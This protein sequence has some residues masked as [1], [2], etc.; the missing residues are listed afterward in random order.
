MI[1]QALAMEVIEHA[2]V[3]GMKWGVR[4]ASQV[5]TSVGKAFGLNKPQH[6]DAKTATVLK[7][8]KLSELSNEDLK[9]L[10]KRMQLEQNYK[11]LVANEQPM[12]KK[13]YLDAYKKYAQN[14]TDTFVKSAMDT[15]GAMLTQLIFSSMGAQNRKYGG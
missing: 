1:E 2:G 14:A 15:G 5:V 13:M 8:K 3:P 9:K 12:G 7:R 6:P 10:T 11:S 4:K